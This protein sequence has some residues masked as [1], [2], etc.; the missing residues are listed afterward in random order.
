MPLVLVGEAPAVKLGEGLLLQQLDHLQ[1][2]TLPT[3][4]PQM[5]QVDISDLDE[6]DKGIYV[7]DL[8][9][10]EN[11]Q[12]LTHEEELIVKITALPVAEVEEVEEAAE[13]AEA[14]AAEGAEQEAAE[15]AETTERE[16]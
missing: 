4:I 11:I 6:V 15:G 14:E 10:P 9:V 16:E 3:D 12:V 5:F 7:S 2:R 1:I 8:T 13:A